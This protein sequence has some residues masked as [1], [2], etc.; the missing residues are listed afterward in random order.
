MNLYSAMLLEQCRFLLATGKK[1][2]HRG[3]QLCSAQ[4]VRPSR[5]NKIE[6]RC[7]YIIPTS[8]TGIKQFCCYVVAWC[9]HESHDRAATPPPP[10]RSRSLPL[11]TKPASPAL[12]APSSHS[13]PASS[14]T[15]I[16]KLKGNSGSG[17]GGSPHGHHA[18]ASCS[19]TE[20]HLSVE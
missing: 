3:Q 8:V 13:M 17:M 11:R 10:I 19:S 2:E 14:P 15:M 12:A 18:R 1:K 6:R 9:A 16:V 7:N 5:G 4:I 20:I